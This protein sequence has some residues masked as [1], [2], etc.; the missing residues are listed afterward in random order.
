MLHFRNMH[1]PSDGLSG[2]ERGRSD[3]TFHSELLQSSHNDISVQAGFVAHVQGDVPTLAGASE[4]LFHGVQIVGDRS[5]LADFPI[6][7]PL[8]DGGGDGFFVDI[9]SDVEFSF[10]H[11]VFDSRCAFALRAVPLRQSV[12]LRSA[13]DL[14]VSC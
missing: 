13:V 8:D 1:D 4:E 6:A 5:D 2:D 9:E 12:S 3:R 11:G 7:V 10:I 14:F